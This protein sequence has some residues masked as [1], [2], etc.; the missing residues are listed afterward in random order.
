MKSFF[1]I[2]VTILFISITSAESRIIDNIK[3]NGNKRISKT[4]IVEILNFKKGINIET[5]DLNNYQKKLLESNF[6]KRNH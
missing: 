2:L 3:V 4:T 1:T 6:F 5:D